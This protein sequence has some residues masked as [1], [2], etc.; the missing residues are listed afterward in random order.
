MTVIF[1][2]LGVEQGEIRI[3]TSRPG[4]PHDQQFWVDRAMERVMSVADS[5]PPPIRD[6]AYAFRERIALVIAQTV[7][8]AVND[9][10]AYDLLKIQ[11]ISPEAAAALRGV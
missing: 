6:Q 8:S 11:A 3:F 2:E 9:Q 10:R 5:A 7:A 4:E 1:N